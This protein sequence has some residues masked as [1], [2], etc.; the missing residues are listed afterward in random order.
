M[1]KIKILLLGILLSVYV[2]GIN[3]T[4]IPAEHWAKEAIEKLYEK[5]VFN[6]DVLNSDKFNGD[7]NVTRYEVAYM[8][9]SNL[10][11]INKNN[12]TN[13]SNEEFEILK[14]LTYEFAPELQSLGANVHDLNKKIMELEELKKQDEILDKRLTKIENFFE[15]FEIHGDMEIT[16]TGKYKSDDSGLDNIRYNS[17]LYIKLEPVSNIKLNTRINY[18]NFNDDEILLDGINLT[19]NLDNHKIIAFK[20]EKRKG[21]NFKSNINIFDY[22]KIGITEGVIFTGKTDIIGKNNMDYKAI[23]SKSSS[24]DIYGLETDFNF[25]Y[26]NEK[27]IKNRFSFSYSEMVNNYR[28]EIDESNKDN[29]KSLYLFS[30]N[31]AYEEFKY[32]DFSV[33]LDYAFRNG[34]EIIEYSTSEKKYVPFFGNMIKSNGA[35]HLYT[36][37]KLKQDLG[38]SFAGG[39]YNSGEFFDLNGLGDEDKELF[40]ETSL[41]KS[42]KDKKGSMG[43]I[44][45]DYK[46]KNIVS[47]ELMYANYGSNIKNANLASELVFL[48]TW[49]AMKDDKLKMELE[50]QIQKDEEIFKNLDDSKHN[51]KY[52]YEFRTRK[53]SNDYKV[54]QN[55]KFKYQENKDLED[56]ED[57]DK[58]YRVYYDSGIKFSDIIFL[59]TGAAFTK[60][61]LDLKNRNS[62]IYNGSNWEKI[63]KNYEFDKSNEIEFGT[64]LIITP[65]NKGRINIGTYIRSYDKKGG[66]NSDTDINTKKRDDKLDYHLFLAHKLK[67]GRWT[68][69]YGVKY[70]LERIGRP[71]SDYKDYDLKD[72]DRKNGGLNDVAYAIGIEYLVKKDTSFEIKYGTPELKDSNEFMYDSMSYADGPQD[73]LTATFKTR[74]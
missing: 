14:K 66:Y 34:P 61:G 9:Y 60:R 29:A 23:I 62:Y 43:K 42:E 71:S 28:K 47:T 50:F 13:F 51:G 33:D 45:Y 12:T 36:Y 10:N 73:T 72:F 22:E 21:I 1:K 55:F 8:L 11:L 59:K 70:H 44:K 6:N 5:K 40:S 25:N 56:Y 54:E 39:V 2:Y 3:Y 58:L 49:N 65:K 41:I 74:F 63:T 7:I 15:M 53:R 17:N 67:K 64:S 57:I 20:D 4:D 37:G 48:N 30:T 68:F 32:I 69:N 27:K 16:Q 18:N 31:I 35:I 38:V 19:L 26:F 46:N 52:I 24:H